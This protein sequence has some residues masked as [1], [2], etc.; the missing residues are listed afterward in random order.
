MPCESARTS[1]GKRA[2]ATQLPITCGGLQ[3][4]V[5]MKAGRTLLSVVWPSAAPMMR[6]VAPGCLM[7]SSRA[8]LPCCG[9]DARFDLSRLLCGLRGYVARCLV[10]VSTTLL[11]NV[12]SFA[13]AADPRSSGF[14]WQVYAA[15]AERQCL[16]CSANS[17]R[18]ARWMT[19]AFD[20]DAFTAPFGERGCHP[21]CLCSCPS[22]GSCWAQ[23]LN[24]S[25]SLFGKAGRT[26]SSL[27]EGCARDAASGAW[28]FEVF[29]ARGAPLLLH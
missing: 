23:V 9:T 28:L 24:M 13:H 16:Q 1:V 11:Q 20:V 7:F 3:P 8:A 27:A 2:A 29:F 10:R 22:L 21:H 5:A 26:V 14:P 12:S 15:A 19:Y 18:M 17:L 4:H 6:P 25:V